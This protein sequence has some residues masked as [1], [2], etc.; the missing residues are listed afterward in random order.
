MN[1][2]DLAIIVIVLWGFWTGVQRGL[3]RSLTNLLGWLLALVL[4]SRF[5]GDVA[6]VFKTL[7]HDPVVQKIAAFAVIVFLVVLLSALI[8]SLLRSMLKALK[9]GIPERI[10]GGIF[11]TAKGTLIVMIV[12]QM[13]SPWVAESPYWQQSKA[14][15]WLG[16]FAPVVVAFSKELAGE[17]WQEINHDQPAVESFPESGDPQSTDRPTHQPSGKHTVENPFS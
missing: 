11:G 12:M 2:I 15:A 13:L 3:V 8:G 4:G 7:T 17:A 16:P 9:L 14:I 1:Y 5:A 6:P 10:A